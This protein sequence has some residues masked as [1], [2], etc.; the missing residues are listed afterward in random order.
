MA[1]LTAEAIRRAKQLLE[2]AERSEFEAQV[3]RA[4]HLV[5]LLDVTGE[6]TGRLDNH[7]RE[8]FLTTAM[9]RFY[10]RRVEINSAND[11]YRVWVKVLESIASG[12]SQWLV[13]TSFA[14]RKTGEEWVK[15]SQLRRKL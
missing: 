11:I 3:F 13:A 14:G 8:F 2:D 10:S 12:R 15:P 5:R 9:E 7:D 4:P 6:F 1:E